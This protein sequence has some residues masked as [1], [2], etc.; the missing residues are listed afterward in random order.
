MALDGNQNLIGNDGGSAIEFHP[1]TL[2]FSPTSG[3][4]SHAHPKYGR[5]AFSSSLAIEVARSFEPL[6][7]CS[8][9]T[10]QLVYKGNRFKV[11]SI[12]LIASLCTTFE[13][14]YSSGALGYTAS[15]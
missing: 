3:I 5:S 2:G 9:G 8:A 6:P 15:K 1:E 7:D 12:I 14:A 13:T 11:R 10:V 4:V